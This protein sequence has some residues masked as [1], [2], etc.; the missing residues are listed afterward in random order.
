MRS[1]TCRLAYNFRSALY[2]TVDAR[3][4]R[5]AQI[6]APARGVAYF[7]YRVLFTL[8]ISCSMRTHTVAIF[9][10]NMRW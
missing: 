6:A 8:F 4:R 5:L 7:I 3:N 2:D 1:T 9:S 10:T